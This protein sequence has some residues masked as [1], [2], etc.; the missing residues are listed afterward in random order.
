MQ[1]AKSAPNGAEVRLSGASMFFC[2]MRRALALAMA[3]CML[4]GT[5]AQKGGF[6][7]VGLVGLTPMLIRV[8]IER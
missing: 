1:A 7:I 5:A 6:V 3:S 4:V 2:G 8:P